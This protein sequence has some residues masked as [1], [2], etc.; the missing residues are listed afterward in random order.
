MV[1]IYADVNLQAASYTFTYVYVHARWLY[2]L[3]LYVR[4]NNALICRLIY[5]RLALCSYQQLFIAPFMQAG[6]I[7]NHSR[8]GRMIIIYAHRA[9]APAPPPQPDWN[10]M[11]I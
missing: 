4:F 6:C 11:Q 1:N 10:W 9:K 7:F 8:G 5:C 2:L 3:Q